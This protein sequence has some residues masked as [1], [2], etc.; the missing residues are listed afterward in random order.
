[1]ICKVTAI[2]KNK[3]EALKTKL[4]TTPRKQKGNKIQPKD[5]EMQGKQKQ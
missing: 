2:I 1:M 3:T 5:Y 4:K